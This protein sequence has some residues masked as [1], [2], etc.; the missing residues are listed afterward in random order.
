MW[1]EEGRREGKLWDEEGKH[2]TRREKNKG[3]RRVALKIWP[4]LRPLLGG[5]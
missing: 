2:E 4:K 1:D 3:S 5:I